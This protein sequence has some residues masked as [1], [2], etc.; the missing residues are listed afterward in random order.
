[1][2]IEHCSPCPC[3]SCTEHCDDYLLLLQELLEAEETIEKLQ[4]AVAS[5]Q[6]RLD[7]RHDDGERRRTDQ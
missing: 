6:E 5:L 1:M 2:L 7:E 4:F 3:S